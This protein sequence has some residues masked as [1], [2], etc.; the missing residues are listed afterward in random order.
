VFAA[1]N[2]ILNK[3]QRRPTREHHVREARPEA[4]S[5]AIRTVT[6]S[7]KNRTRLFSFAEPFGFCNNF[8]PSTL[9]LNGSEETN[10]LII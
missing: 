7:Y 2:G 3:A 1:V 8:Q 6:R 10:V 5:V 9:D 4:G